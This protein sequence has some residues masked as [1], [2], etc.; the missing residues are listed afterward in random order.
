MIF[1]KNKF[2]LELKPKRH[3]VWKLNRKGYYNFECYLY[4]EEG[5]NE[6]LQKHKKDEIIKK[7]R[8]K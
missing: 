7:E 3:E 2:I 5:V 6:F 8:K 4:G 1:V